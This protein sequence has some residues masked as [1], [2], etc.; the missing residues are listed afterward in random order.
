MKIGNEDRK[1]EFFLGNLK[2]AQVLEYIS[3]G[4]SYSPL[5]QKMYKDYWLVCPFTKMVP[6]ECNSIANA[7]SKLKGLCGEDNFYILTRTEIFQSD[8]KEKEIVLPLK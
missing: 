8:V 4:I 6:V 5:E 7:I 1:I 2:V 3:Y